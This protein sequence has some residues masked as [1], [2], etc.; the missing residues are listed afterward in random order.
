MKRTSRNHHQIKNKQVFEEELHTLKDYLRV[1]LVLSYLSSLVPSLSRLIPLPPSFP[2]LPFPSTFFP[3]LHF[4]R[5]PSS[6]FSL[7]TSRHPLH[8][9]GGLQH[10]NPRHVLSLVKAA[11]TAHL[12]SADEHLTPFRRSIK[13]LFFSHDRGSPFSASMSNFNII[14]PL[15]F[16]EGLN[17]A[18]VFLLQE[19]DVIGIG[20]SQVSSWHAQPLT[21]SIAEENLSQL[22]LCHCRYPSALWEIDSQAEN[23]SESGHQQANLHDL[24]DTALSPLQSQLSRLAISSDLGIMA[25]LGNNLGMQDIMK[26]LRRLY[27]LTAIGVKESRD[28]SKDIKGMSEIVSR[29]SQ[30]VSDNGARTDDLDSNL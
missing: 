27:E 30:D 7:P 15:G 6:S 1:N 11:C 17:T 4:F 29:I 16:N 2:L 13:C 25:H 5:L 8:R 14:M 18:S 3:L 24:D 21:Q 28:T 10:L 22:A 20:S 12:P 23:W 9:F 19:A 26:N